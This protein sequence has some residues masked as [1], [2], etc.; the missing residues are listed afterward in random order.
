MSKVCI[1][2][3]NIEVDG[4]NINI[5]RQNSKTNNFTITKDT[6]F[7]EDFNGNIEV[8]ADN[9]KIIIEGDMNGNVLG[10]CDVQIEGDMNG[11]M[12]G[13]LNVRR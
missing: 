1:D 13:N 12:V 7:K 6:T 2:G 10:N 8:K 3:L 4:N 9:V 5:N 11:N